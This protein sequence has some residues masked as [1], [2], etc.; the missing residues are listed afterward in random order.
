MMWRVVAVALML[1]SIGGC[2]GDRGPASLS[3]LR[4]FRKTAEPSGPETVQ[5]DVALVQIPLGDAAHYHDLWTFLDEQAVPLEKKAQLEENGYRIGRVGATPPRELIELVTERRSNPDPRR[6]QMAVGKG[7]KTIDLG[8]PLE[9]AVFHLRQAEK[10]TPVELEKG[11]YCLAITPALAEEGGTRLTFT[12]R[13][14]HAG[15]DRMPWKASSERSEWTMQ[16]EKAMESYA[17]LSWEVVLAPGEYLVVGARE[18]RAGTIGHET[19]VRRD[20]GVPVKRLLILRSWR[21]DAAGRMDGGSQHGDREGAP[22][23]AVQAAWPSYRGISR[24][25]SR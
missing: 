7:E 2:L 10:E 12:P 6:I 20:E 4:R 5:L 24:G 21:P 3:L 11:T 19:F 13:V 23:L 18:D 9:K 8:P 22:P 16:F 1:G 15:R 25:S 14:R 17:A